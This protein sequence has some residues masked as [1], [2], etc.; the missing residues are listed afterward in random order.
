MTTCW[1]C[2]VG[3]FRRAFKSAARPTTYRK[4]CGL[5][6]VIPCSDQAKQRH[7][8]IGNRV[9]LVGEESVSGVTAELPPGR[10]GAPTH[11]KFHGLAKAG[12]DKNRV[13]LPVLKRCPSGRRIEP[14]GLSQNALDRAD[15]YPINRC[16][17]GSHHA[18]L[19][20]GAD[21]SKLRARNLSRRPSAPRSCTVLQL[22]HGG[23]AP[24]ATLSKYAVS[25]VMVRTA[26]P[27]PKPDARCLASAE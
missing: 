13:P 14:S 17:L 21:A 23:S 2:S 5:G 16:D 19:H 15:S 22:D 9:A 3:A 25:V 10:S 12:F 20:P 27:N 6:R 24:V 26:P 8:I 18:I 11:W 1:T 7:N 4:S